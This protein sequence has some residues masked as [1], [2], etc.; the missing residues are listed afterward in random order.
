MGF[1][2]IWFFDVLEVCI[3]LYD[4]LL[5]SVFGWEFFLLLNNNYFSILICIYKYYILIFIVVIGILF[6]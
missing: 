4:C 5:K 3:C 1:R 2:F 6:L